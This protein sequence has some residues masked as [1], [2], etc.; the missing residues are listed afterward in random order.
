VHT[1]IEHIV[2]SADVVI[3]AELFE[4]QDRASR[5]EDELVAFRELAAVMSSD[6]QGAI[7]RFLQI[8][9][10]LCEAGSAGVSLLRREE[11]GSVAFRWEAVAGALNAFEG[12]WMPRD[13]SPCGFC[14]DAAGPILVSNPTRA[15]THLA[16]LK[17]GITEG[18]F[19]PLY[20]NARHVLGTLW[21]AHHDEARKFVPND[22]RV[23]EQLGS[24]LVLALKLTEE[25]RQHLHA[26]NTV[27]ERLYASERERRRTQSEL[28]AERE[29]R[30]RAET[31]E[32]GLWEALTAKNAL[33]QEVHHRVK[34]SIQV[35]ASLLSL[36]ARTTQS[37]EAR[38]SLREAQ[39]RLHTLAKVH[40]LLYKG[41][42]NA[43]EV[44]MPTL[45][46]ALAAGLQQSFPSTDDR[47]VLQFDLSE[48]VMHPDVAIPVALFTNEALTNAYKHAF[49][50][51]R[52]GHIRVSL[53]SDPAHY[54]LNI[55]DD[56]VGLPREASNGLGIKLMKSFSTQL[57]GELVIEPGEHGTHVG[58][59]I[60]TS[61]N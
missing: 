13:Q 5:L 23:L 35:T 9:L 47:I 6:A 44:P 59:T 14:I 33:I 26:L 50:D 56:G 55:T 18:L 37:E 4:R 58:L 28:V 61:I 2:R 10:Q 51:D 36:Q 41:T 16:Y 24:Q 43:Q 45:L 17:P 49:P 11:N 21:V 1:S 8:S 32:S 29:R 3:T 22:L 39:F 7:R 54:V 15:L 38:E 52:R 53:Q 60:P 34:N 19:V 42:D 27:N 20:D 25:R 12:T 31:S 40:E 57:R 46:S 48:V 30:E